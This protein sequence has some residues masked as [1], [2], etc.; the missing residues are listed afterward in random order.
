MALWSK[1]LSS[2]QQNCRFQTAYP[3]ICEKQA[4]GKGLFEKTASRRR[5][6]LRGQGGRA[7]VFPWEPAKKRRR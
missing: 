3:I 4:P 6:F 5:F 1:F 7:R 2:K